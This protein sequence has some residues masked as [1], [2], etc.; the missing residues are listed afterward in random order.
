LTEP[1][2]LAF[3]AREIE[4]RIAVYVHR[5][6][7]ILVARAARR[8]RLTPT[9]VTVCGGLTGIAGGLLLADRRSA[10]LG[11]GLLVLHGVLDS[12]DGQLAR[13]T[14]QTSER[15]RVLDGVAGYVTHIAIYCGVIATWMHETRLG[16]VAVFGV[17]AAAGVCN[18]VHAQMYDY[19]RSSYSRVV[20]DGLAP[21]G[22]TRRSPRSRALFRLLAGYE[23]VQRRIASRHPAVEAIIARRAIDGIVSHA[24]RERYRSAFYR[25]VRGWN[26]LG[27]NTRFYALGALAWTHHVEWFPALV[28][29]PMNVVFVAMRAW[30]ARA[31]ERFLAV[32]RGEG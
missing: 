29:G 18:I 21:T 22:S 14:G 8:L 3:K 1:S 10:L 7:G 5:P 2:G 26:L 4:E 13:M 24:D 15:G 11:F 27:D 12:S 9:A 16:A 28:L 32:T 30:Q 19:Y 23:A 31:D 6:L 25:L 17:A 20:V